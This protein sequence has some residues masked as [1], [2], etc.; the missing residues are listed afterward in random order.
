[1]QIT[2]LCPNKS[3]TSEDGKPYTQ[4]FTSESYMDDNNIATVYCP[5]CQQRM[6]KSDQP[7]RR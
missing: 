6:V 7:F 1:M 2:Y 4:A 5:R 3:C